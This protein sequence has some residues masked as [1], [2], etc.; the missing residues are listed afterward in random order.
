MSKFVFPKPLDED[1]FEDLVRDVY[2]RVYSNR[3]FQRYG[4]RGQKQFGVDSAGFSE[5]KL[6]GVQCKNHPES[7]ISTGEIDDEIKKSQDFKPKLDEYLIVTSAD[8]D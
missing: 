2:A 1:I 4:R 5:E 7:N 3:N 8:R 6:I